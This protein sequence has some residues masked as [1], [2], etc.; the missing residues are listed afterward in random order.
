MPEVE[1]SWLTGAVL[2]AARALGGLTAADLAD[3]AGVGEAT[4]KRA[5]ASAGQTRLTRANAAA[6]IT[7]YRAVGVDIVIDRMV[8]GDQVVL[9]QKRP[10]PPDTP[11]P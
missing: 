11:L 9:R 1:Y 3:R 6:V 10:G 5:E 2:R 8:D 7:A 4:I